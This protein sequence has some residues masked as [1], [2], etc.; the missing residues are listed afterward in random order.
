[1]KETQQVQTKKKDTGPAN[2]QATERERR[3][4]RMNERIKYFDTVGSRHDISY[5]EV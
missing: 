2:V 3:W 5:E 4:E 1:M